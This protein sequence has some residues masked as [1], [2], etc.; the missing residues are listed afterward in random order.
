MRKRIWMLLL[1]ATQVTGSALADDADALLLADQAPSRT[2][3]ASDWHW[4]AEGALSQF[5]LRDGGAT[6]SSQRLSLDVQL[7]KSLAPGWRAVLADRLDL[8]RQGQIGAPD[9][10]NTLRE[11]YLSWQ[12]QDNR[13]IDLGRINAR[14]GV[15]IGYNP[16]DYFRTGA[17]RSVVSVDPASL[18]KNRLGSAMLRGQT[19]WSGGSLTG[20][21]SPKLTQQ[22]SDTTFSPDFGATNNQN[23]WLLAASQQLSDGIQPQW[24]MYGEQGQSPQLGFN[25]TGLLNDATVGYV[26]WS[27]GRSRSQ[28]LQA[29]NGADDTAFRNRLSTGLTYTSADKISLTLE[30]D[31]NGAALD[32]AGWNALSSGSP[33]SYRQ[34]RMWLQN[35]QEMPT[36]QALF[37]YANWQDAMI[38]HLDFSAMLRFNAADHS[39]LS[40]LE[41]RYHWDKADL[42]LQW[43]INSGNAGSEFGAVP[44]QRVLELL[45]RYFF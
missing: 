42:A 1:L 16:T 15:A 22:R 36:R 6:A 40:W 2:A 18:K 17:L 20:L 3:V 32:Q 26:E 21:V 37:L 31:Y 45:L 28:L 30:Y 39:R 35:A 19:L 9:S 11:A 14:Y 13:I 23:R 4:F 27:G 24:L 44:Q 8:N 10:I 33:G 25:L 7:D 5:A 34:Y 12:A 38:N 29:L 43:Q 41:A